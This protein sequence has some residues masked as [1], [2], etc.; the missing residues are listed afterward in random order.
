[1]NPLYD[2]TVHNWRHHAHATSA[3]IEQLIIR[4]LESEA[5]VSS[6]SQA[7]MASNYQ[8]P[9]EM[10]GVHLTAYFGL[11]E[12]TTALLKNS[13]DLDS[14][15]SNGRMPLSWAAENRHEAVVKLLLSE[16][17]SKGGGG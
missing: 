13:H 15:D 14:M 11:A 3:K 6:S 17:A 4:L 9:T 5:K 8:K 1:M 2:Y 12:A 10:I 7:M 16:V